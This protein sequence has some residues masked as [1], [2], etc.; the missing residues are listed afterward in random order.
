MNTVIGI[1]LGTQALKLVFYD[2]NLRTV[3]AVESAPLELHQDESG[4][5]EQQADWWLSALKAAFSRVDPELRASARAIAVSGQQHGFVA[6]DG[7]DSVLAPVKLWC[8]TSTE[9]ECAEIMREA[10][11]FDACIEQAGNPILPGYTASKIRWLKKNHPQAYEKLDAILLPHDYLNLWLTGERCMEAGDA[12]GTG[13]LDIRERD[14]SRPMLRA[15]DPDRDLGECLPPLRIDNEAVGELRAAAAAELGIPAGIP[16]AIG[17]GDN[18]MGA[19]GTGN[20]SPGNVTMSLGT[21]GTVY[22]FAEAPVIDPKGNIAAFCSSTGGW[23]PLL[24]TMNCTVTTELMRDLL[25]VDLARFESQVNLAPRGSEGVITL[26]FFNGERTPNLPRARGCVVGLDGRNMKPENFLR[27]AVEGATFALK[28]GIDELAALGVEARN[29]V[30]TGGGANSGEWRQIVADVCASPVTVYEQ[31]EGAAFGAALQAMQLLE[32][33]ASIA[34]ICRANLT[35]SD[36]LCCEPGQ[37]AVKFYEDAY[38]Q[39]QQ[40]VEAA[41]S[42]YA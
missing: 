36:G 10:G 4:A 7:A 12:S 42:L 31:E 23:L 41:S 5:A 17:G 33:G 19:I 3:A 37:D 1:D 27:S 11:G 14:W 34:E 15:V 30:L 8:D 25:G 28:F 24:C 35:R 26:P 39:Y 20:V 13:L 16:V 40:A 22:A 9:V 21:S 29:I 2:V 6:V 38:G 32:P 18:M